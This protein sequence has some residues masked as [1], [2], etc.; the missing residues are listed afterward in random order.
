MSWWENTIVIA[1]GVL[2]IFNLI[3]KIVTAA[4]ATQN[5]VEDLK[6]R[7]EELEKKIADSYPRYDK[8]IEEI[9]S[10]NRVVQEAIY[11]LLKH[12]IDGNNIDGLKK[13]EEDLHTYLFNKK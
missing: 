4:K 8:K 2:T 9:E 7:V 11:Q 10:G 13:A 12:S 3:D 6:K 5:P 1:A